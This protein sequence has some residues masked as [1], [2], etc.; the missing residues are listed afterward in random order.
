MLV[1]NGTMSFMI[2]SIK[3]LKLMVFELA[4]ATLDAVDSEIQLHVWIGLICL[5]GARFR[6]NAAHKVGYELLP[7]NIGLTEGTWSCISFVRLPP[8]RSLAT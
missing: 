6:H 3:S 7:R 4:S 1:P 2:P 5:G 8:S